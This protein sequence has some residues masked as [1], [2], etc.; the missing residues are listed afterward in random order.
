MNAPLQRLNYRA[1]IQAPVERVWDTMLADDSYR[2]WTSAF[3]EGSYYE[4]SWAQGSRI[5]F[6]TPSGE[7]M[8]AEIAQ[9]QRHVYLSIRH[10]GMVSPGQPAAPDGGAGAAPPAY[11][12]YR[13]TAEAGGTRLDIEQ[14]VPPEYAAMMDESWPKA[15]ARLKALCEAPASA[16]ERA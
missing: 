1:H 12:N 11:E 2:D 13:F 7:G 16:P 5:R 15:L 14:D 9:N 3:M 10:L 4:G 8:E 6:L